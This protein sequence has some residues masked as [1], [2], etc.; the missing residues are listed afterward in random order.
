MPQGTEL[1]NNKEKSVFFKT[2]ALAWDLGYIIA[3]PL[4][5]LAFLGRFLDKKYESSPIFLLS[6]ILLAVAVSG[7]MVFRKTK[8]I[9]EDISKQ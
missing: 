1:K 9:L 5:I 8:K 6:G 3:G 7:I 2:V 4:V